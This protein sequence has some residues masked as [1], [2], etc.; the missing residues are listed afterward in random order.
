MAIKELF[1][2]YLEK[3][4]AELSLQ[5]DF[6]GTME[7]YVLT[8]NTDEQVVT[9]LFLE[10]METNISLYIC[11]NF[12]F[13]V[14]QNVTNQIIHYKDIFKVTKPTFCCPYVLYGK[15]SESDREFLAILVANKKDGYLI[16]KGI[17]YCL[18]EPNGILDGFRNDAVALYLD[19]NNYDDILKSIF[20]FDAGTK[21]L[22]AVQ[23]YYDRKFFN[24]LENLQA[25]C[26]AGSSQLFEDAKEALLHAEDRAEVINETIASCFLLKKC[27][28]VQMMMNKGLLVDR[29]EGNIK[30]QRQAAK[31][32][33]DS[34]PFVS[35]S[36]LWRYQKDE[37]VEEELENMEVIEE[38]FEYV[39]IIDEIEK[40]EEIIVVDDVEELDE[41][42]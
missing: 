37:V 4:S 3:E 22:G 10:L 17:Y 42:N 38:E 35:Y 11:K 9:K 33:S 25:N 12:R 7:E 28:Y 6:H 21:S 8:Y 15:Q 2:A 36:E 16:A 29:F 39:E 27:L 18:T 24:T 31:E 41:E 34:I 19:D 20:S 13:S 40:D 5:Y 1:S 14:S 26:I 30:K 32:Y 23:R